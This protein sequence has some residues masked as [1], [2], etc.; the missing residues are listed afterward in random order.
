MKGQSRGLSRN[1]STPSA[2]NQHDLGAVT[3][4]A[5]D[6]RGFTKR[7]QLQNGSPPTCGLTKTL[8]T[9]SKKPIRIVKKDDLSR[10][11]EPETAP[12]TI[13]TEEDSARSMTKTV[14]GWIREFKERSDAEAG[15]MLAVFR[16]TTRPSEV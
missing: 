1:N 8:I 6:S 11:A 15:K 12:P 3:A 14:T 4:C 9:V 5:S 2:P 13:P 16:D 7:T 10:A